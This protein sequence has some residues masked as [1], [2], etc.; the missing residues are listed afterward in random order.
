M[1]ENSNT[2]FKIEFYVLIIQIFLLCVYAAKKYFLYDY[3]FTFLYKLL[4]Q[5][6]QKKQKE[7]EK[8][9]CNIFT[10]YCYKEITA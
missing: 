8:V 1:V 10:D 7:L 9:L 6:R 4:F 3:Y 5:I 2:L